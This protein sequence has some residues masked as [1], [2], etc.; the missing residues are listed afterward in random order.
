M[1]FRR[2]PFAGGEFRGGFG[3]WL[4]GEG[5]VPVAKVRF[6]AALPD[7]SMQQFFRVLTLKRSSPRDEVFFAKTLV[8]PPYPTFSMCA[9]L[10]RSATDTVS[11]ASGRRAQHLVITL[12]CD[13]SHLGSCAHHQDQT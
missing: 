7:I 13:A 9:E 4:E 10:N 3:R 12:A 11:G 5:D 2:H 8:S 6:A 1:V